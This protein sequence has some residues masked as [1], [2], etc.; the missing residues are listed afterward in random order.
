MLPV[1]HYW[2]FVLSV[3]FAVNMKILQSCKSLDENFSIIHECMPVVMSGWYGEKKNTLPLLG[4]KPQF[5][6]D[7]AH[8][9]IAIV[10]ML[11]PPSVTISKTREKEAQS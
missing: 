2:Q 1:P 7:P 3:S 8:T 10:T 5:S 4:R 9:L 11:C 6:S